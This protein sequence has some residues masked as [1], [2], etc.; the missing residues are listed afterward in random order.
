MTANLYMKYRPATTMLNFALLLVQLTNKLLLNFSLKHGSFH[1][2]HK[3]LKNPK[4][5]KLVI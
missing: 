2:E 3:H 4:T 1:S 5:K